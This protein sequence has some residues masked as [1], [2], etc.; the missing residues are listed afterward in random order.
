MSVKSIVLAEV[1]RSLR[2][3]PEKWEFGGYEATCGKITIWMKNRYYCTTV[4]Y[5]S[6]EIG[7]Q[8]LLWALK[9]WQWWRM[10]LIKAVECAQLKRE[11]G[12]DL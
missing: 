8:C 3:D 10:R 9:P 12:R 2:D 1:F 11:L 7:G 5:G 6:V 4:S